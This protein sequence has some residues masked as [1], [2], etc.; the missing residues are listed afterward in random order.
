MESRCRKQARLPDSI[1]KEKYEYKPCK[2]STTLPVQT[3]YMQGVLLTW[4]HLLAAACPWF[5]G[6]CLLARQALWCKPAG[7]A[8]LQ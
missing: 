1:C 6:E 7:T 2:Y 8:Y 5:A 3:E 4:K